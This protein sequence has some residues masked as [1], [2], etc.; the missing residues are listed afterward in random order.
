MSVGSLKE[1]FD[2][3]NQICKVIDVV[4]NPKIVEEMEKDSNFQATVM[5]LFEYYF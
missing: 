3:N 1:D 5:N 4:L 2:K